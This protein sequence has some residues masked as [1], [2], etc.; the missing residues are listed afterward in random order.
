[1][2]T[3]FKS[4][5]AYWQRAFRSKDAEIARLATQAGRFQVE[6]DNLYRVIR[7]KDRSLRS[8]DN[9]LFRISMATPADLEALLKVQSSS[10]EVNNVISAVRH[11]VQL[12]GKPGNVAATMAAVHALR[13]S[14]NPIVQQMGR[15]ISE[16]LATTRDNTGLAVARSDSHLIG[17]DQRPLGLKNGNTYSDTKALGNDTGAGP[18]GARAGGS[19]S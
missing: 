12:C 5:T 17:A 19:E 6:L 7:E 2:R 8:Y 14:Q 16:E 1:M 10:V 4:L 11:V 18:T 13:V 3:P 9:Q 15:A